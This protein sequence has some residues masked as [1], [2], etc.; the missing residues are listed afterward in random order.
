M[1]STQGEH[2]LLKEKG[3]KRDGGICKKKKQREKK[4][5]GR[6][7][8]VDSTLWLS[9]FFGMYTYYKLAISFSVLL[10]HS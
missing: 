9:L 1:Q 8:D 4:L 2:E 10:V 5:N 7:R 6:E 3:E